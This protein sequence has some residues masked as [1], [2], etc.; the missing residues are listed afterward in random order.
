MSN[1]KKYEKPLLENHG[2]LKTI[3]KAGGSSAQPDS[4]DRDDS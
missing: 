2:T 1:K 4:F 3:T